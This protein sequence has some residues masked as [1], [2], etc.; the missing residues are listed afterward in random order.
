MTV[1]ILRECLKRDLV[2]FNCA[3]MAVCLSC[4][5]SEVETALV[6]LVESGLIGQD[7]TRPGEATYRLTATGKSYARTLSTGNSA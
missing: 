3:E 1:A 5:K 2:E 7:S 4:E 6:E